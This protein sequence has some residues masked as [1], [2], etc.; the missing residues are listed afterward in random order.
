MLDP[1]IE[2]FTMIFNR[3]GRGIGW[4]IAGLLWP[5]V[6]FTKWYKRR[7]WMIKAPIGLLLLALAVGYGY[8]IYQTQRWAGFNPNY[9]NEYNF[10]PRITLSGDGASDGDEKK[11]QPSAV[12]QVTSDLID[13]TVN[14][15]KWISSMLLYKMGLFGVSWD[16]TP[17]LDDQA[18][19][20]RGIHQATRRIGVELVDRLGRIRGTSQVDKSLQKARGKL[21]FDEYTWYFGLNP[22]GFQIPTPSYYREA[23][24]SLSKFNDRLGKCEAL[25]DARADNLI[26]LLDR[27]TSDIGSTSDILLKR[28]ENF[29]S[30]WFD[31]R[32][33][34]RF[35]FAYGQLYA[36]SGLL[37][38]M[39]S[40]FADVV[41]NRGLGP[42][43]TRMENQVNGALAIR[44][45]IISNGAEDGWIMP[46]HLAT[47]GFYVLRVRSNMVEV[48]DVLDR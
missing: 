13:H 40:D 41:K 48:R 22:L 26:Q 34:D 15:N 42:L 45:F 29:D 23:Q 33:D 18:S 3:I 9:A 38:A 36:Y 24:I 19:F 16:H 14:E 2:F 27:I 11:C 28:S 21:Q 44:P 39:R 5:F 35:W 10:Q 25:F 46:T 7:G 37:K 1:V 20:Q 31:S 4:M 30:G 12:V 6:A 47:I 17:Y 8:F 43:W 32:A